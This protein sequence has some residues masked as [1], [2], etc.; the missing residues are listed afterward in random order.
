MKTSKDRYFEIETNNG[1][2]G[3]MSEKEIEQY[4]SY[5]K[6]VRAEF[7]QREVEEIGFYP[8]LSDEDKSAMGIKA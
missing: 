1:T 6:D 2:V 4:R 3:V 7:T 5:I 8:F